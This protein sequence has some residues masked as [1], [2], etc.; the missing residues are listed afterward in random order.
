VTRTTSRSHRPLTTWRSR[1]RS[2]APWLPP[3]PPNVEDVRLSLG[4][5]KWGMP[6]SVKIVVGVANQLRPHKLDNSILVSVCP[7]N[8]EKYHE[9]AEMLGEHLTQV[10]ELV[11]D[12][13]MVGGGR[14]AV[15]LLL[16]RDY[17]ALFTFYGHKG[18]SAT[19]PLL[20]CYATKAPSLTHSGLDSLFG[21]LQ[22]V[23]APYNT[24]LRTSSHLEQMVL[25]SA[26]HVGPGGQ[27]ANLPQA[28]HRSIERPGPLWQ[29]WSL[30]LAGNRSLSW[31][32]QPKFRQ[33]CCRYGSGSLRKPGA[34][35]GHC[36]GGKRLQPGDGLE[37][38]RQSGDEAGA[39]GW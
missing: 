12:G 37:E 35:D 18:P 29:H 20:M 26:L 27:M 22:D 34:G 39:Q 16:T 33:V 21:S 32:L 15:R 25:A 36:Q 23:E 6:S 13:V 17:E 9:V 11:R 10:L 7:A 30:R 2:S 31:L 38:A 1:P 3:P 5:V 19:M 24:P 8:R 28:V 14:C 4:I